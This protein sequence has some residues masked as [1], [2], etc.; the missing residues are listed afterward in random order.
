MCIVR[1]LFNCERWKELI[2]ATISYGWIR[3]DVTGNGMIKVDECMFD[4]Y[5]KGGS[6][7]VRESLKFMSL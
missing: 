6:G 5:S 3:L 4:Y 1:A 2:L 7:M